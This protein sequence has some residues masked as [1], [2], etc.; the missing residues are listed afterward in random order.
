MSQSVSLRPATWQDIDNLYQWR[1]DPQIYRWFREQDGELD[2]HEHVS[3]FQNRPES[4]SDLIIEYL[5]TAVGVVS[6]AADADV[7][8]YIGEQ[9]LWGRGIASEALGQAV[10]GRSA[11]LHAEIHVDN[12]AS[13]RLFERHGFEETDRDDD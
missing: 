7:G 12:S 1:N 13:V 9:H 3:W 5:G 6:I 4:R 11:Q 8:I 10:E 2:W